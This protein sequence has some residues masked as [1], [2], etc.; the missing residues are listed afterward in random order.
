VSKGWEISQGEAEST[1]PGGC[2]PPSSPRRSGGSDAVAQQIP[3][4]LPAPRPVI[5]FSAPT[6]NRKLNHA[7]HLI[8]INRCRLDP[9]TKAYVTRRLAEGK[10]KREVLRCL[11]RHL[12]SVI[13]RQL[14][15]DTP[16]EIAA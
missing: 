4:S 1:L 6:G 11:Q 15:A 10:A 8:A 5:A 3:F 13:F 9:E 12:A 2:F 7:L 16:I 14:L